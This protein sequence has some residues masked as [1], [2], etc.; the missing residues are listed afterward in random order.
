V[1]F[2]TAREFSERYPVT[3]QCYDTWLAVLEKMREDGRLKLQHYR[4][5]PVGNCRPAREYDEVTVLRL[6]A[7]VFKED[8]HCAPFYE[9]LFRDHG[10]TMR[11]TI[12]E[13]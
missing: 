13:G 8:R 3:E 11:K 6:C 4:Y 2:L 5:R 9:R 12:D 7:R 1:P 10:A